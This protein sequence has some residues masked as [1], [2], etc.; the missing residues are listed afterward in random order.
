VPAPSSG[1]APARR[2]P[3]TDANR[4]ARILLVD[5]A[6]RFLELLKTYLKRTTCRVATARTAA[7]ALRAC[8]QEAPDLVFID[9]AVGE[10]DGIA[11]T[12][13]FKEE[14]RLRAVP[15]VLVSGR[16][17]REECLRAGCDHVLL[18]PVVQ[19]DF[20]ETVRR[21]VPLLERLEGRIPVSLRV[22]LTARSGSYTVYTKDLSP[23]GAFLKTPR[24]FAPG[25]RMKLRIHLPGGLPP[26]ALEGEVR[27]V[28][29]GD[30][31]THLLSGVGVR[32]PEVPPE[33]LR[34]LQAFISGRL[35][36]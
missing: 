35:G 27:R 25:T 22:E 9:S 1:P 21:F 23:H 28:V 6:R 32:F 2:P 24:P 11:V 5:D 30:A 3:G 20:L 26:L 18:K 15:V 36:R 4:V 14:P 29:P 10:E 13:A 33:A 19:E 16:D 8:R 12:R 17:R 7:E 31:G 34:I